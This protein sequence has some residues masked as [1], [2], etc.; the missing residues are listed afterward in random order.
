ME[1][2]N[3]KLNSNDIFFHFVF[4]S[5]NLCNDDG[6][7]IKISECVLTILTHIYQAV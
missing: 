5:L 7:Q 3:N 1:I 6:Y 2:M 4:I